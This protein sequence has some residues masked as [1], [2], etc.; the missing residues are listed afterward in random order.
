MDEWFSYRE[1]RF[2]RKQVLWILSNATIFKEGYW[3]VE[4]V[5]SAYIDLPAIRKK[6]GKEGYFIKPVEILAEVLTRMEQ[7]GVDGLILL[8]VEC[9]GETD[10]ALS[11]YLNI[12]IWSVKK[13]YKKA[14][15]YVASGPDRRWHTT[16]RR[17]GET[18]EQF[19][20]RQKKG[21]K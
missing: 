14:L 21:K 15:R 3:P 13:R 9:W 2:M 11:R 17:K 4:S 6:G 19:K 10:T 16:K 1:I 12:P 20:S 8:A 5:N 7:C 18:Y